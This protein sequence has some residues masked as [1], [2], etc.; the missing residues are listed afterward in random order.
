MKSSVIMLLLWGLLSGMGAQAA[1]I[2][3][4]RDP[5]L[6]TD[7]TVSAVG[8]DFY[9]LF[10]DRWEKNLPETMTISERPSARWGSWIT[11]KV[12][13]D[14]LYQTLLFPN[15]HNFGKEV[16]TAVQ[17]VGEALSRRQIDKT[18]LGTG[19]LSGDEF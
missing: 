3:D 13:Q 14:L 10:T 2:K 17:S 5:G 19:D 1:N 7:H 8:H 15:R 12:G 4:I 11:I 9:R 16:D 6:I 18:L